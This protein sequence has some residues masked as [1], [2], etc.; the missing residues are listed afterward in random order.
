MS[1]PRFAQD[2]S[3]NHVLLSSNPKPLVIDSDARIECL[4]KDFEKIA[5]MLELYH[6]GSSVAKGPLPFSLDIKGFEGPCNHVN[7]NPCDGEK[8]PALIITSLVTSSI[9][10]CLYPSSK[11]LAIDLLVILGIKLTDV[12][13]IDRIVPYLI[14]LLT[15]DHPPIRANALAGLTQLLSLVESLTAPDANIFPDYILP[16]LRRL[17]NDP[18][19]L[20]RCVF[21]ECIA[22]IAETSLLF[23]EFSEALKSDPDA[24]IDI[25]SNLYQVL[26][27]N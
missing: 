14:H 17:A 18:S 19:V 21:A 10:N 7:F 1:D 8:D 6:G 27:R 23:L 20:V 4:F 25:D 16:A 13:K 15:D 24:T 11:K 2:S 5:Q 3:A 9:R 26:Y 12:Y 22:T